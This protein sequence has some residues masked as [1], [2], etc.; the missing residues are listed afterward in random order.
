MG[1]GR[2]VC[3]PSS[4]QTTLREIHDGWD[5]PVSGDRVY[6]GWMGVGVWMCGG[7]FKFLLSVL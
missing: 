4:L 2:P 1:L 3:D 7:T 6:V 5:P